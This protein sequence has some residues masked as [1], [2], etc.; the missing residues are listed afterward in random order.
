MIKK[1][2]LE[3]NKYYIGTC[4][5]TNIA[6]WNGNKFIFIKYFFKDPYVETVDYYGDVVNK[7][8]DGF[9]PIKK[10]DVEY[11]DVKK[12]RLDQDYKNTARK[13]YLNHS[14]KNMTGEI[15]KSIHNYE[16]YCV[17]NYGRVKNNKT[18]QIMKQNF[19]RE[20]LILG[21]T[22]QNGKRKT[23]RVHR[24]VSLTFKPQK[25]YSKL[26]VNHING[27]KT[28]NRETNLE[29]VTHK[30]NSEKIYTSGTYSKKLIPEQVIKIKDLLQKGE[31]SQIEI[32]K[33]FNVS[34]S[35]ISEINTKKKWVTI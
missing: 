16:N 27:V 26:E 20:Y 31:L 10:I 35:L 7:Q 28:D 2:E 17:S 34:T 22:G 32:A 15:W 30:S 12:A 9:I 14:Q 6:M 3:I 18:N 11:E 8:I 29:W 25:K 19:S 33:L 23:F 24:L 5:N 13:I 21:L 4:R 1:N